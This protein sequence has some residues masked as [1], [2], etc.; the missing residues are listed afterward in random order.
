M[1]TDEQG[2][3]IELQ[4]F[5][6]VI[7]LATTGGQAK[8]LIRAGVVLVDGKVETKLRRKLRNGMKIEYEDKKYDV[9]EA[10]LL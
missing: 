1:K 9:D 3:Y 6:K 8:I 7:G 4:D 10:K 5:L 2:K